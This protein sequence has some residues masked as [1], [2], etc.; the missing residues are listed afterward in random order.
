MAVEVAVGEEIT[1]AITAVR[2]L[3][4]AKTMKITREEAL[5]LHRQM[6]TDMQTALGDNPTLG[7]R[8]DYKASWCSQHFPNEEVDNHCF[9]C[10]YADDC[11]HCPIKWDVDYDNAN[12]EGFVVNYL[13]SPISVILALP[14]RKVEDEQSC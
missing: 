13:Y 14:E 2:K 1:G 8:V 12:C 10:E 7:E 11:D 9:L 4:G 5:R 6:W 3:I